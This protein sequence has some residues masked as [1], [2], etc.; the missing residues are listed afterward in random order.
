MLDSRGVP[1]GASICHLTQVKCTQKYHL[2]KYLPLHPERHRDYESGRKYDFS[3]RWYVVGFA[4]E[5]PHRLI[6]NNNIQMCLLNIKE[7]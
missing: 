3:F 1:L 6:N 4:S 2:Y 5:I 7:L